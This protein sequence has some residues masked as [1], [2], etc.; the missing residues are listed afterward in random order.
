MQNSKNSLK[1]GMVMI[2]RK[3]NIAKYNTKTAFGAPVFY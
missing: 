1:L 2:I 3:P